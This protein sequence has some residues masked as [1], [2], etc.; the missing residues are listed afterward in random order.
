MIFFSRLLMKLIGDPGAKPI[1]ATT[2]HIQLSFY[3]ATVKQTWVKMSVLLV[4][5]M[6]C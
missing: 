6:H 2:W 5:L 1:P 3:Y 4:P